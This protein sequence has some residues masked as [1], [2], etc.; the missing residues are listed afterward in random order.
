MCMPPWRRTFGAVFAGIAGYVLF[1]MLF[2][3]LFVTVLGIPVAVLFWCVFTVFKWM[4]L[5]SLFLA[6]GRRL[7]RSAGRA[8]SLPAAVVLGFLPFALLRLVPF[9]VGNLLWFAVEI[10]AIGWVIVS[11]AGKPPPA[12]V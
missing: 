3:V 8:P 5:A 11:R 12:A 6:T 2:T 7:A 9:L 1:A 4:G 10:V